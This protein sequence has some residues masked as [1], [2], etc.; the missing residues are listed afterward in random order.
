MDKVKTFYCGLSRGYGETYKT[1]DELVS[2]LGNIEIKS[3]TDQ[4]V[5]DP[6]YHEEYAVG[7]ITRVV[8]YRTPENRF[9]D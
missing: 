7:G 8:V 5:P 1:L 3:L 2:K 9:M 6:G 4:V